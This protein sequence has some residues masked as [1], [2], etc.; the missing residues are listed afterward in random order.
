MPRTGS[1]NT[2]GSR[3][4]AAPAEVAAQ[5]RRRVGESGRDLREVRARGDLLQGLL[6][7]ATLGVDL[8]GRRLL[9]DEHEHVLE[10]VLGLAAGLRGDGGEEVVDL[11][12][13]HRDAAVDLAVAQPLDGDLVPHVLAVARVA[14]PFALDRGAELIRGQLVVLNDPLDRA[15]DLRVVD[16]DA[17]LLRVLH[18]RA[19][20]DQPLEQL[21]LQHV[22]GR[23]RHLLRLHLL[24]DDALLEIE[25][26][27][28]QRLV[29]DDGDDAIEGDDGGRG[30]RGA[31]RRRRRRLG[32]ARRRVCGGA[33]VSAA[34]AHRHASHG[35]ERRFERTRG[36]SSWGARQNS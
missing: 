30:R 36:T 11:G 31:A 35:N 3:A 5:A 13:A 26:V 1:A 18:Q 19:V 22:V 33:A 25:V 23:R 21:L 7:A 24:H 32:P 34:A 16:L 28:R 17:G 14:Q 6:G 2:V 9:R 12:V 10:A 20:D 4:S 29:V 8:V 27:L 15:L